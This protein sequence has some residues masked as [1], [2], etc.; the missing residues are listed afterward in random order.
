MEQRNVQK[1]TGVTWAS[2]FRERL[3]DLQL[4]FGFHAADLSKYVADVNLHF[5]FTA[6]RFR[7]V[8]RSHAR[9]CLPTIVIDVCSVVV[10]IPHIQLVQWLSLPPS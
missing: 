8:G 2:Q 1:C 3:N 6:T 9:R 10:W 5:F 4:V 7:N